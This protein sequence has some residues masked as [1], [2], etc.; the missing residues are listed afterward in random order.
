MDLHWPICNDLYTDNLND[1]PSIAEVLEWL[2]EHPE[3]TPVHV[4]RT[5]TMSEYNKAVFE[6]DT[7]TERL[8]LLDIEIIPD[9]VQPNAEKLAQ[10]IR[11]N[12]Q[13]V[14]DRYGNDATDELAAAL[15]EDCVRAP[16]F[17]D[18]SNDHSE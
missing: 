16:G 6:A 18:T 8:A 14:I 5:I 17:Y 11:E 7:F 4:K 1:K 9:P 15:T 10:L 2:D 3:R 12:N 13:I